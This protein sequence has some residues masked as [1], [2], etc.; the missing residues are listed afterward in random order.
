MTEIKVASGGDLQRISRVASQRDGRSLPDGAA[1][2]LADGATHIL[3]KVSEKRGVDL[4]GRVWESVR[5]R[6]S[7]ALRG[8]DLPAECFLDVDVLDWTKLMHAREAMELLRLNQKWRR[9]SIARRRC[10][11]G[12][13]AAAFCGPID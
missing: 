7:V 4:F 9:T 13:C 6:A 2:M 11:W 8:E 5:A 10:W 3:T 1:D 12:R